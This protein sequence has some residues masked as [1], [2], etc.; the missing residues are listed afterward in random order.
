L[1]DPHK[2]LSLPPPMTCHLDETVI[3]RFRGNSGGCCIK[4]TSRI[5]VRWAI[6]EN[7]SHMTL[8]R[9]PLVPVR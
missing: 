1:E 6:E 8:Q 2:L 9:E 3:S 5:A 7:R 4:A